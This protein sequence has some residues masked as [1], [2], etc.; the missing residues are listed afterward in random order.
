MAFAAVPFRM[1]YQKIADYAEKTRFYHDDRYPPEHLKLRVGMYDWNKY[2]QVCRQDTCHGR[3][4]DWATPGFS[5]L[6]SEHRN[7]NA[8]ECCQ[9]DPLKTH[10]EVQSHA[11]NSHKHY[12][13]G[14][15]KN[16]SELR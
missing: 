10:G 14:R 5:V 8:G 4:D 12:K 7:Q 15:T 13:C 11:Q 6:P 2:R 16:D 1:R 3:P 9:I